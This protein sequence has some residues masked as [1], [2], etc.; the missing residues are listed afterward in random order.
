MRTIDLYEMQVEL[1]E[2][3]IKE[4]GLEGQDL[5][6]N[7]ALALQVEVGE[8]ANEWRY[9]KHWS[10][11]RLPRRSKML[12]EYVDCLHFI[13]GLAR[14]LHVNPEDLFSLDF[15]YEGKTASLFTRLLTTIGKIEQVS[16]P[17]SKVTFLLLASN[18]FIYLGV[19]RLGFTWGEITAAYVTKNAVNHNRQ[20]TGY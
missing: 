4:K 5:I 12:V 7:T 2:R 11:D 20:A 10:N 16:D 9:F 14:Q 3:I 15:A 13:L 17:D 19:D 18:Y 1:D 8:C 6:S